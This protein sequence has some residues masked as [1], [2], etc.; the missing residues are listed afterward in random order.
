MGDGGDI[1]DEP[2][3]DYVVYGRPVSTQPKSRGS[4]Q[5]P[6]NPAGLEVWRD[7]IRDA[8]RQA[9]GSY[10]GDFFIDPLRV[11]IFWVYDEKNVLD[12]PDLD[13]IVKPFIDSLEGLLFDDDSRV[14]EMHLFKFSL[15]EPKQVDVKLGKLVEAFASKREFVYVRVTPIKRDT[16]RVVSFVR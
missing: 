15:R 7:K 1:G 2:Y 3:F 12:N 6:R 10:S 13:N 4:K 8:I 16:I 14:R 9:R 11:D 5:R